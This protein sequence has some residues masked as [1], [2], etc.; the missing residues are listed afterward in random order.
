MRFTKMQGLG[1]DY[2]YL[3]CMGGEPDN[4]PALAV[5]LSRPHFGVGADGIICICP[6][7]RA[8][9]AMRIFNADGSEGEMCG[10][11]IRCVGKYLYDKGLTGKTTLTVDTLAGVKTLRLHVVGGQVEAVTVDM[12]A[13]EVTGPVTLPVGGQDYQVWPVSMGNPHAV[14]FVPDVQEVDL[15]GIGP[16]FEHHPFFPNRTNTEFVQ[17]LGRDRMALRVWERGSGATLACGT[18]A[19]AAL[20]AGA[21]A[22]HLD[23]EVQALLPGGGLQ[24]AWEQADNHIYMTGPAQTVFEGTWEAGL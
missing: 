11:G 24:L 23:R 21:V 9:A 20:A 16:M 17:I 7:P 2:I 6:S 15:A 14:V 8:D 3:N 1:N 13:P 5:Q 10:N 19:C 18:G 4:L 22:G 12:G